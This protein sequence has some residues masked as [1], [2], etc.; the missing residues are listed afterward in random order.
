MYSTD[1][2]WLENVV[3]E[4]DAIQHYVAGDMVQGYVVETVK[5]GCFVRL[6]PS[7]VGRVMI[8]NLSDSFIKH[9]DK[10]FYPTKLVTGKILTIDKETGRIELTLK[11]SMVKEGKRGSK[12]AM[13][14]FKN[15]EIGQILEGTVSKVESL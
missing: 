14:T 11:N 10:V 6:S 1:T 3:N 5:V 9:T 15:I 13:V 7:V 2:K 4:K 12:D 8:T